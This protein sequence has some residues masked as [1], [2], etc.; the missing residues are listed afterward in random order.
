[1][2]DTARP[3][4][5]T[6]PS[7]TEL[8]KRHLKIGSGEAEEVVAPQANTIFVSCPSNIETKHQEVK[9]FFCREAAGSVGLHEATTFQL[10]PRVRLCLLIL[11]GMDLLTKLNA[12]NMVTQEGKYTRKYLLNLWEKGQTMNTQQKD[13]LSQRWW[14]LL[15]N[16][17]WISIKTSPVLKPTELAQLYKS[18]MEQ[19]IVKHDVRVHTARFKQKLLDHFPNTCAHFR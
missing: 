17:I 5:T 9:C 10:D 6:R 11:E 7:Q 14:C 2:Y 3:A 16:I 19:L 4:G 8:R 1:M 18:R 13:L 15:K 12:G